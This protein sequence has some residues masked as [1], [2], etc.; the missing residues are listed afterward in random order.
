MYFE[1]SVTI[2]MRVVGWYV[3]VYIHRRE[4]VPSHLLIKTAN[5]RKTGKTYGVTVKRQLDYISRDLNCNMHIL[6][7]TLTLYYVNVSL[8]VQ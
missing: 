4:V 5:T 6:Q 1:W 8:F 3:V 7:F 2:H